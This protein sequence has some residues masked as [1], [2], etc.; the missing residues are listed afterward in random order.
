MPVIV[1][2]METMLPVAWVQHVVGFAQKRPPYR[3]FMHMWYDADA[4]ERV[5]IETDLCEL[6]FDRPGALPLIQPWSCS[7]G[8]TFVE[9]P[10]NARSG[11]FVTCP[12]CAAVYVGRGRAFQP[13]AMGTVAKAGKAGKAGKVV[14]ALPRQ[15]S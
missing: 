2:A 12:G 13:V 5:K 7:C 10:E 11:R 1:A 6:L 4:A 9:V 14:L 3:W 15:N 8:Y